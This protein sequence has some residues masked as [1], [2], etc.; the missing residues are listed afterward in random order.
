MERPRLWVGSLWRLTHS[1]QAREMS[2]G[3]AAAM[4]TT[5]PRVFT[6]SA[7]LV[8]ADHSC[9]AMATQAGWFRLRLRRFRAAADF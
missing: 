4:E 3:K 2:V 5:V 7:Q 9:W 1:P 6:V 8:V